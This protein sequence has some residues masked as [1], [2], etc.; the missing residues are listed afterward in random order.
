MIV[1]GICT[2]RPEVPGLSE[3]IRVKS[4]VG[5]YLEH[6]RIYCFANGVEMPSAGA[7]IFMS[8]S[9]LMPRN[10]DRRIEMLVPILNLT[11]HKQVLEQIMVA[12][13]KD[14]RNS[15]LMQ[16][17]GSYVHA[18]HTETPFNAHEYFMNNPSLSGRGRAL[19]AAPAPPHLQLDKRK[20]AKKQ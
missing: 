13:L 7:K 8:S 5:R 15:W 2:L 3:N 20:A 6:A 10:L 1:R 11:V 14:Q 16:P 18:V 17:D 9:D 12:N 19:Q 4:I